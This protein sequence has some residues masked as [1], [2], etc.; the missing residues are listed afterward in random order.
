MFM[1]AVEGD[2]RLVDQVALNEWAIGKP[3][4][5]FEGSWHQVCST[6]FD[7]RDA[8][9]ACRQLGLGAATLPA[10]VI[11][12][13]EGLELTPGG[14]ELFRSRFVEPEV[15]AAR[16]GCNG[17]EQRLLDCPVED[18]R[19]N[20]YGEPLTGFACTRRPSGFSLR[21]GLAI[22]CV[23]HTAPGVPPTAHPVFQYPSRR[24]R[25]FQYRTATYQRPLTS[26]C[27]ACMQC[28]LQ[29]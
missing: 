21:A 8:S 20:D 17:T 9:V 2:I 23:S 24:L 5:F 16:P 4:L 11:P 18:L 13:S 22:A 6:Q 28:C 12:L 25:Q 27:G 29:V 3:E 1:L 7:V 19:F 26:C 10:D 15:V 14:R